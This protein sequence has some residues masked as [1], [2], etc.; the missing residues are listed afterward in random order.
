MYSDAFIDPDSNVL[1]HIDTDVLTTHHFIPHKHCDS[2]GVS[3]ANSHPYSLTF[4]D[5][6]IYKDSN[7]HKDG[8]HHVHLHPVEDA[9]RHVNTNASVHGH[10]IPHLFCHLNSDV[11]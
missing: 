9:Q 6:H 4:S 3:H 5:N 7:V 2:F 8:H 10:F 11:D 1:R